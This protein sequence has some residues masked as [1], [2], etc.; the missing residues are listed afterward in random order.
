MTLLFIINY[1]EISLVSLTGSESNQLFFSLS[2][3]RSGSEIIII[4]L[5]GSGNTSIK[6]MD[7]LDGGGCSF[8]FSIFKKLES[9]GFVEAKF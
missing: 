1:K 7:F 9:I 3:L 6:K 8:N 2:N 5:C 4:H